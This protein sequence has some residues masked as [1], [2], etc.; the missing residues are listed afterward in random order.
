[1]IRRLLS[2][3]SLPVLV[4]ILSLPVILPYFHKGYFPTHDGEWAVVRLSDMFRQLRDFQIPPRY[5]GN[6]NFGYGYPLFNFTYPFPYFLGVLL[7]VL[8]LNFITGIKF[9]FAISVPLSG[10]FMYFASKNLWKN[11]LAGFVSALLYVYLPYRMVDLYARGSIGESLSFIFFPLLFYMC[12]KV[13]QNPR[14]KP[15]VVIA[16]L[17]FAALILTHNIMATLFT[18]LLLI[19]ITLLCFGKNKNTYYPFNIILMAGLGLSTFFWLPA[20]LEKH[21]ILLS[22]VPIADRNL[23]FVK[24]LQ[25]IAPAWGYGVPDKAGGFSYQLGFPQL[26]VLVLTFC[27]VIYNYWFAKAKE[28]VREHFRFAAVFSIAVLVM[29]FMLFSP[30]A[31]LWKLPLL[32]EINYPWTLLAPLGFLASLLAGYVVLQSRILSYISLVL[33]IGAIIVFLPYAKPQYYTYHDDSYY[34][35]NDATTTSSSELMPLWVKQKPLQ[36]PVEK[37]EVVKGQADVSNLVYN[38][39]KAIF[40]VSA[41]TNSVVRLNTIYYPGWNATL[42]S[43][44]VSTRHDNPRGVMDI[45]V[46]SGTHVVNFS[47]T[48]TPLR[49]IADIISI[50][51]LLGLLVY[52]KFYNPSGR[53]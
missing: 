20:I 26:L 1:M 47:F 16:A 8:H 29:I 49:L 11:S 10:V 28:K 52:W 25:I 12:L 18:P 21:N 17:S 30:S 13:L 2:N 53:S 24:P 23:Y 35:T 40:M 39:K 46:P 6:L 34:A 7:H 48:E 50:I 38:S 14:K 3:F 5:S 19:F 36:R 9:L 31:M 27:L 32:S 37:V 22:V 15:F 41:K 42:D 51:T 45:S 33:A 4:V 43:Q 44:S